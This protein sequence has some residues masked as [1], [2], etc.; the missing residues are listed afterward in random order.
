MP[1]LV[2]SWN[3]E[4]KDI[5]LGEQF[6]YEIVGGIHRL[7]VK[8]AQYDTAGKYGFKCGKKF[9]FAAVTMKEME[10]DILSGATDLRI[11][12][13]LSISFRFFEQRFFKGAGISNKLGMRIIFNYRKRAQKI[14]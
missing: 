11:K 3:F 2:G 10:I 13:S 5:T 14:W 9:T 6:R 1:K 4:D 8:K 7:H 12:G